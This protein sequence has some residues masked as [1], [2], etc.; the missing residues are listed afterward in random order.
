MIYYEHEATFWTWSETTDLQ[1]NPD[2]VVWKYGVLVCEQLQGVLPSKEHL[3]KDAKTFVGVAEFFYDLYQIFRKAT[4]ND[5]KKFIG[6]AEVFNHFV[7][8]FREV[9]YHLFTPEK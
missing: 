1:Y 6:R 7:K 8:I 4:P 9:I 5:M 2:Q 3:L